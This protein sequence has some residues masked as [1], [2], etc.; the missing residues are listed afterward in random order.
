MEEVQ[1]LIDKLDFEEP[2]TA[3]EFILYDESEI[4][5]GMMISDDEILKA[6]QLNNQEKE[7]VK[8]EPLLTI[9]YNEVIEY[10]DKVILY[11]QHQEKNYHSNNENIKLIKKLKKEALKERFGSIK[12]INLDNF[13]NVIE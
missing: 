13:V 6:V 9:T 1:V 2:F 10:Y 11:L 12:Q 3:E 7:K 5:T 8:K 4:T